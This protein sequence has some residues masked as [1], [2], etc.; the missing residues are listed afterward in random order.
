[1]RDRIG[2]FSH[3]EDVGAAVLRDPDRA[4]L[5]PRA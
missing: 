3:F 4:H 1:L 2:G 5:G